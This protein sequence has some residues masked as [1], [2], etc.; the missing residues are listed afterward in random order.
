[1]A[2]VLVAAIVV[3]L[4]TV[5][6]KATVSVRQT[7]TFVKAASMIAIAA[8]ASL[9]VAMLPLAAI[10]HHAV[11]LPHVKNLLHVAIQ[12]LV[13]TLP[14]AKSS[15]H[16][17]TSPRVATVQNAAILPHVKNSHLAVTSPLAATSLTV[18]QLSQSLDSLNLRLLSQQLNQAMAAKCLCHAIWRKHVPF[19]L[20]NS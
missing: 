5:R 15:L 11:T 3:V 17:V 8:V 19:A 7:R 13:A 20:S 6:H 16:V 4:L 1:M 2:V 12:H 9:H 14:P 10:S 18:N